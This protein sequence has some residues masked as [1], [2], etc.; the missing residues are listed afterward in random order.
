M[1]DCVHKS[2]RRPGGTAAKRPISASQTRVSAVPGQVVVRD[3]GDMHPA[4]LWHSDTMALL[5]SSSGLA[6]GLAAT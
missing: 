1:P 5:H 3:G 6:Q 2:A 4:V